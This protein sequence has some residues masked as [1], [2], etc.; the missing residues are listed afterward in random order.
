MKT[1]TMLM[2]TNKDKRIP[3]LLITRSTLR[4]F[5]L[6]DSLLLCA[7]LFL[8]TLPLVFFFAS[9]PS[10][11]G[12]T[13]EAP[14]SASIPL[15]SNSRQEKGSPESAVELGFL[16][17]WHLGEERIRAENCGDAKDE[18]TTQS[19]Q[20]R[21]AF[22]Y[23]KGD[24]WVPF[25]SDSYKEHPG[26][27]I[28]GSSNT[29]RW[30]LVF[31]G[32]KKGEVETKNLPKEAYRNIHLQRV[33]SMPSTL[34]LGRTDEEITV[35]DSF[36]IRRPLVG[37]S[38]AFFKDADEWNLQPAPAEIPLRVFDAFRKTGKPLYALPGVTESDE[39]FFCST[40]DINRLGCRDVYSTGTLY[41]DPRGFCLIDKRPLP[42]PYGPSDLEYSQVWRCRKG[43]F[44]LA[45]RFR[46]RLLE[47]GKV[48]TIHGGD[49]YHFVHWFIR[50]GA[51]G[52]I[53]FLG[54]AMAL[55]DIGDYDDDGRSEFVF[56]LSLANYNGYRIF[57]DDFRSVA[58]IDWSY[59]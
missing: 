28:S 9:P 37:C 51:E 27:T 52:D 59:H 49:A 10:A 12:A 38:K 29:R 20:L 34:L 57:W 7:C 15:P 42:L 56:W 18:N 23:S 48:R 43:R 33:T 19:A 31:R 21:P 5:L 13:S 39:F 55:L 2:N 4:A 44:L 11:A 16:E 22:R 24:G 17:E 14:F 45:V 3:P 30:I 26:K 40:D 32:Q 58:S 25:V 1:V 36:P 8:T 6:P 54:S 50:E 46:E 35:S 41:G 47:T 53:R